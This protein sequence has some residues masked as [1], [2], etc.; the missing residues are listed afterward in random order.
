L[1]KKNDINYS[2]LRLKNCSCW[3]VVVLML[4]SGLMA[5]GDDPQ[6]LLETAKFEEQQHNQAH[7]RELY[8][9]IL[10]EFPESPAARQAQ[11]RLEAWKKEHP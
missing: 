9:R 10:R 1:S 5:C 7:A 8:E 2:W 3:C 4:L 11:E 6:Q